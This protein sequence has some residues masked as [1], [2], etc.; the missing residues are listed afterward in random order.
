LRV[1]KNS[2]RRESD[3][4]LPSAMLRQEELAFI[5]VLSTVTLSPV[6]LAELQRVPATRGKE[7]GDAR[8]AALHYLPTHGQAQ[9]R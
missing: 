7:T 5:K 6:V 9:S 2:K 3:E 4:P 8:R 1:K